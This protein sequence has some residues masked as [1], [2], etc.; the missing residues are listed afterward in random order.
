MYKI[1]AGVVAMLCFIAVAGCSTNKNIATVSFTTH[2]TLTIAVGSINNAFGTLT[3]INTNVLPAQSLNLVAAFRNQNGVSAFNNPGTETLNGPGGATAIGQ[4]FSYGQ[5]PGANGTAGMPTAYVPANATGSGY[6]TGFIGTGLP[7]TPGNYIL[8]ASVPANG[9]N[10]AYSSN[11]AVLPAAPTVLGNDAGG[12]YAANGSTGGGTFTFAAPPA[13]VTESVVFITCAAATAPPDPCAAGA[14]VPIVSGEVTTG[15]SNA[16][17]FPAGTFVTGDAYNALVIGADY[18][19]VEAGP[20]A[21]ASA[22][23]T[24][25]G[26]NGTADITASALVGMTG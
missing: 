4:I 6:A 13:G 15:V 1:R 16:V 5:T 22:A 23:P 17:V 7:L 20:P 24:L 3:D 8:N 19:L 12:S 9:T 14:G 2:P 26:A 18:P 21:N 25:V 11:T 10:V